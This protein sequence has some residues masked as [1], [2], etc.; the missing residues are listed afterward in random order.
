MQTAC[1]RHPR[2]ALV[3]QCAVTLC[4]TRFSLFR[5]RQIPIRDDSITVQS[6][7]WKSQLEGWFPR[8]NEAALT[9]ARA[10]AI[11]WNKEVPIIPYIVLLAVSLTW[12]AKFQTRQ[13]GTDSVF[14]SMELHRDTILRGLVTH[15]YSWPS[16]GKMTRPVL[17]EFC[18]EIL[19]HEQRFRSSKRYLRVPK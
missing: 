8:S 16:V 1:K 7:R 18:R 17:R 15:V 4:F 5:T 11:A 6:A 2:E 3:V 14:S 12:H 19:S 9:C 10:S 13:I